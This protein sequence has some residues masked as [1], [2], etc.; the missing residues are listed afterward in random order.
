MAVE[1]TSGDLKHKV[2]FKQ[3]AS[4]LNSQKEKVITYSDTIITWAKVEKFNQYRTTEAE[5]AALIGA[6][7]FYIRYTVERSAIS[8]NWLI[9]YKGKDYTIHQIEPMWQKEMFIRF[10]AKVRV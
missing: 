8:K 1:I 9:E 7:D 6:L 10:T 2:V 4:S 5:S 3:P